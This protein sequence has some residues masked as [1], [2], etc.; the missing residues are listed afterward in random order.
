MAMKETESTELDEALHEL[1]GAD[2]DIERIIDYVRSAF[3]I[4][5]QALGAMGQRDLEGP[6]VADTSQVRLK[7]ESVT[8]A[9]AT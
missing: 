2:E 5:E 3:P 8:T 4:Y 6:Q 1:A 9:T 7:V